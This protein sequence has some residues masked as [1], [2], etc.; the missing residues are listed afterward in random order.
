MKDLNIVEHLTEQFVVIANIYHN[1]SN[2]QLCSAVQMSSKLKH[3][4]HIKQ[5]RNNYQQQ[6]RMFGLLTWTNFSFRIGKIRSAYNHLLNQKILQLSKIQFLSK[7]QQHATILMYIQFSIQTLKK[8]SSFKLRNFIQ[9]SKP[10]WEIQFSS[11]FVSYGAELNFVTLKSIQNR[12]DLELQN[13]K[14]E[15]YLTKCLIELNREES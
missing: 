14:T 13:N 3:L 7:F 1:I 5:Y 10:D 11:I 12:I 15:R 6:F 9:S 2:P 4:S 8:S